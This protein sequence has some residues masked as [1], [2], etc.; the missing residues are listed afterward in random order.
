M[1]QLALQS[2]SSPSRATRESWNSTPK[3]NSYPDFES[4]WQAVIT[5]DPK[6]AQ[7]FLYCVKST[8]IFCRP[9]CVARLAHRKNAVFHDTREDALKAG[10]RPCKRCHPMLPL[11]ESHHS[12]IRKSCKIMD[13]SPKVAPQLKVLADDAGLSQWHFHRMFRRFTGITPKT[14]WEVRH[15]SNTRAHN[16]FKNIDMV[17]LIAKIAN[18]NENTVIE[19]ELISTNHIRPKRHT[20]KSVKGQNP[21]IIQPQDLPSTQAQLPRIDS[22]IF[23]ELVQPDLFDIHAFL[24]EVEFDTMK[25]FNFFDMEPQQSAPY[26][27]KLSTSSMSTIINTTNVNSPSGTN[28]FFH[29]PS[30]L[31]SLLMPGKLF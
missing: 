10:F 23:N 8:G 11:N 26:A 2:D 20:R 17:N 16:K 13:N 19:P 29:L 28:T 22:P 31:E 9:T 7:S 15:G 18:M 5:R 6:A 27:P 12:I 4:K 3:D 24:P 25:A 14:Y 30:E 21:S 1:N